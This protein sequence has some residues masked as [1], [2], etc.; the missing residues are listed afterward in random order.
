MEAA[1]TPELNK[2]LAKAKADFPKIL[3]NKRVKIPTKTGREISFTY[4]ELEEIAEAVTP[5]LSGYGLVLVSQTTFVGD[6]F[7]LV[8]SLRHESGEFIASYFP[9]PSDPHTDP[10]EIG[11]RISYGRRYNTICLLEIT[12][13]EPS[14][15]EQRDEQVRKLGRDLRNEVKK[16]LETAPGPA[17]KSTKF[18]KAAVF[19]QPHTDS[20]ATAD[21]YPANNETVKKIRTITKH[22]P[23]WIFG[24]CRHYGYER[25]GM[26]PKE[27]LEKLITDMCADWAYSLKLVSSF[28]DAHQAASGAI[29]FANGAGQPIVEAV[30]EWLARYQSSVPA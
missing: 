17:P 9:L 23:D 27:I 18:S 29:S 16:E 26:M 13:I 28:Q 11:S 19:T 25:P 14:N 10:K 6:R 1:L 15:S 4:S 20:T 7:C 12:T 2:A 24:Q 5:S 30:L 3:E 22:Q 8:T 21:L